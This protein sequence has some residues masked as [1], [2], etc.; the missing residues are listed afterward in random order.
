M[1]EW[2]ETVE[3]LIEKVGVSPEEAERIMD[4]DDLFLTDPS[5]RLGFEAEAAAEIWA[6]AQEKLHGLSEAS[7]EG[8]VFGNVGVSMLLDDAY[9][10]AAV[11]RRRAEERA[12]G[13]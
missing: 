9:L 8:E 2:R 12:G 5:S 1:D 7:S 13:V 3:Y 11:L 4:D 6:E 10:R